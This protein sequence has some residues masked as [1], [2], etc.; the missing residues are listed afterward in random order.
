MLE[1][2]LFSLLENTGDA[3]FTVDEQGLICSWN[4]AAEK[5][6][7]FPASTVLQKPCASL[8]QG[9]GAEGTMVCSEDCVVLKCGAERRPMEHY[10]LEVSG[11]GGQRLWLN[12]SILVHQDT[13]SGRRLHVHLARDITLRKKKEELSGKLLSAAKD[14]AALPESAAGRAP[15]TLLSEQEKRVLRLL[16]EGKGAREAARALKISDRTLRNHLHHANQKLGTHS[17]LEAVLMAARR[18]ML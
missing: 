17:R 1:H 7:G 2:E 4:R 16:G 8:F 10:D 14:L 3:A 15:V 5:L 11:R 12:I 13:R 9:R 6:F 18:G